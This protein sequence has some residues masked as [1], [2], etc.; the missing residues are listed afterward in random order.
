[1]GKERDR[2]QPLFMAVDNRALIDVCQRVNHRF[3]SSK[4]VLASVAR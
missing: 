2:L 3:I 4:H 1:M